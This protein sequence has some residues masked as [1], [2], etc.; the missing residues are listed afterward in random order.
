MFITMLLMLISFLCLLITIGDKS[1]WKERLWMFG[2]LSVIPSW[3]YIL[4]IGVVVLLVIII[5]WKTR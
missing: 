5:E 1:L 2:G 4:A 3:F